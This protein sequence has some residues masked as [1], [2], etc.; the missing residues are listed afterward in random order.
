MIVANHS[1]HLDTLCLLAALPLAQIASRLSRRRRRI[2]FS[3]ACRA[4]WV[5]AVV[6]NALPFA[7]Q[8]PRATKPL[9]LRGTARQSG[10]ILIIFPEGTRS[11]TGE[12]Q[13]FKS[14]IGALV[15]GRDVTV[16]AV[17]FARR[18]SRVAEGPTFA[19]SAKSSAHCWRAAQL[20]SSRNAE[21]DRHPCAIAAEL[22]RRG[23]GIGRNKWKPTEH[24][25]KS[26]DGTELFY[27]AW[28]PAKPTDKAL[29]LFHR[30]HEHSGRWQETVESLALEDIAVFAWDARGH[31]R[32][33]GERGAAN[34]LA[35]C[36][37]RCGRFCASHFR[38]L[39]HP[40]RKHDRARAQPRRGHRR[41]LG[42]RLRAA[43][44]RNDSGDG[45]V[46]RETLRSV[47]H[48]ALRLRKLFGR[49]Y[50]KSYVKAKMLTHDREQ[51]ARYDA[52]PLIFRQIA[53]NVLARSS[54]H[55]ETIGGGRRRNPNADV[56]D[57]RGHGLGR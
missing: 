20:S 17:L 10:N 39:R 25:L 34:N 42:A 28:I 35:D 36:D 21:Q 8:S 18:F 45:C 56:D 43:D 14:G 16:A 24:T 9:D 6:I 51:A 37:Q 57:R 38:A 55:R 53:V 13:E 49:G 5:A 1:S 22:H 47:R 32:S 46:S 27:R 30:G 23:E 50:V 48:S 12:T 31:G 26:W 33:P 29:L 54:R 52:D 15:A 41:G 11:T 40:V 4:L 7:R 3:K 19:A 44:S 2:I